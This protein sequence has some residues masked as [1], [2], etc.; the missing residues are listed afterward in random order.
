[1]SGKAA[2]W[3]LALLFGVASPVILFA[4]DT[5]ANLTPAEDAEAAGPANDMARSDFVDQVCVGTQSRSN[6]LTASADVS[7]NP[8]DPFAK[9]PPIFIFSKLGYAPIWPAGPGYYSAWDILAGEYRQKPPP[10]PWGRI[11][12][13]PFPF[14][15]TDFRYLDDPKNTY[16]MWSDF[17]KR[18][19]LGS[20]WLFSSGGEF[21]DRLMNEIDSRLTPTINRYEQ[22]RTLAYGSLYYRDDFGVF[23]Q[24][25]D[26]QHLGAEL[27]PLPIDRDRSDLVDLFVDVKLM[28]W[29]DRPIYLRGG[30]QELSLGSQRLVS[31]LEWANTLRTF[32][33]VR[34][35]RQ[36]D[37]WDVTAFWLQ[38][39]IPNPTY[40]DSPDE[41]QNFSGAWATYRSQPGH[42]WDWYVLNLDN[43]NRIFP[44]ESG[45]LGGANTTTL[46][47]RIVGDIDNTWLYDA[48]G[49]VQVG[50]RSN[51]QLQA[52]ASTTGIGY[53]FK[54]LEMTP[55]LWIYYDFASGDSQPGQGDKFG[56]FNHLF[57]FGHYYLGYLDLIARQNIQDFNMQLALYPTKWTYL[58]V[59]YHDFHLAQSRSP[60]FS[61]GGVPI[62][63][64][65]TGAAGTD[66]GD[67]LD[68]LVNFHLTAHQDILLGFSKLFP[69][70]FIRDTGPNVSPELFY[71]QH[72]IR[73]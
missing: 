12:L 59:Q 60:L 33:G 17:L 54:N 52:A 73:W 25:L 4:N 53:N 2:G 71:L 42:F 51:Q 43:S 9:T 44:G 14:Y 3:I 40:F 64:D 72:Q 46:G 67:E 39:I 21:R 58:L 37:K 26:A 55:Q 62:R 8:A 29:D 18:R 63:V 36:G 50:R 13:K 24:Y 38:P 20:D 15:D 41:R 69:G 45:V 28:E 23:I 16:F 35:F 57:P 47:T 32:Q 11:S 65:P 22:L 56:T 1:M 34:A 31:N 10:F 49:M 70:R 7:G 5:P 6:S 61:A 68:V 48:E 30:R 27:P 19:R 66:V